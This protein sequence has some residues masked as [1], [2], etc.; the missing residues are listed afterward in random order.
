[1]YAIR[2]YYGTKDC[3]LGLAHSREIA[4]L[5]CEPRKPMKPSRCIGRYPRPRRITC[6]LC[7]ICAWCM[8]VRTGWSSVITSYS[9]HYTKL[10]DSKIQC[11][12]IVKVPGS[13]RLFAGRRHLHRQYNFTESLV[14]TVRKSLR[15]SCRSELTRQGISLP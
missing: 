9:I 10:Y 5:C 6:R 3:F 2:S 11:Q 1:M 8:P 13:F 12:A 15:H 14:E 4:T 7:W